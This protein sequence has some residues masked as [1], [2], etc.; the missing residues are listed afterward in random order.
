VRER[1]DVTVL[2]GLLGQPF[3]MRIASDR[4]ME[5]HLV[6]VDDRGQRRSAGGSELSCFS[7]IFRSGT[8]AHVP[9]AIYTLR[10]PALGEM[11]VFLVPI[12]PDDVGMRYEAI[13]N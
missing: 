7:L 1:P 2:Q 12:G 8:Q 13:F 9:Q 6:A 4:W 3:G 10:H 5:V 11:D